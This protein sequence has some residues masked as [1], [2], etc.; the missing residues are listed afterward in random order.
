MFSIILERVGGSVL[1]R[2]VNATDGRAYSIMLERDHALLLSRQLAFAATMAPDAIDE[3]L[4][5]FGGG[6]K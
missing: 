6:P 5:Q 2:V 4:T 1:M 3:V